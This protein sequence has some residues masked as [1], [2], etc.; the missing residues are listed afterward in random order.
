M[1]AN[2]S[3]E[4]RFGRSGVGDY[5][6]IA[7]TGAA[8]FSN[9]VNFNGYGCIVSK[10]GNIYTGT[11]TVKIAPAS[12]NG[13]MQIMVGAFGNGQGSSAR[14]MWICGGYVGSGIGFTE[15]VRVNGGSITISTLTANAG[16]CTFTVAYSFPNSADISVTVIGTNANTSPATITFS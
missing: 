9:S 1:F 10:V 14:A 11:A 2:P 16:N 3:D 12:F 13:V 4:M 7:N 6:T 8:S 15:V 5:L